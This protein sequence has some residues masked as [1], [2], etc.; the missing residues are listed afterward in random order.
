MTTRARAFLDAAIAVSEL[1]DQ[2]ADPSDPAVLAQL[3]D[4]LA[5]FDP[6]FVVGTESGESILAKSGLNYINALG[7]DDTLNGNNSTDVLIGGDGNDA[8]FGGNRADGLFGGA[9]DDVLSGDNGADYLD[10]GEGADILNGGNGADQLFG[11][12]GV[13]NLFGGNGAD[14]LNGGS[15]ADI[16]AGGNGRDAF[17]FDGDPFDGADVSAAGRQVIANEDFIE[18]FD[19]DTDTILLDA[20]DFGV[21]GDLQFDAIDANLED[22]PS[23]VNVFVLLNSDNDA[24]PATA[25]NAGAAANQLA[26]LVD[27][28]GAGFFV[29][30]NSS[31]GVNR[32]VYSTNLNDPTADLKIVARFN[33]LSGDAA[34]DALQDFN[35]SNF[36]FI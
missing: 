33:D 3:N 35:A 25:F 18:D 10:G 29:Y 32:L 12:Q 23:G 26:A 28:D 19:F 30:F 15:G 9:G 17:V 6:N 13:D 27:E 4:I 36:A 5:E 8:L 22:A 1:V 14:I 7:G 21:D 20:N 24:D 31:L 11:E 34:V 2:G 16:L